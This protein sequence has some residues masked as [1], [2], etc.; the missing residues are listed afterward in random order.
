MRRTQTWLP[1]VLVVLAGCTPQPRP[2]A[3]PANRAPPPPSLDEA[4]A[5]ERGAGVPRDYARAAEI[6]AL[7]CD[8]G[9]GSIEACNDL[10]DAILD[11]RGAT[12]DLPRVLRLQQALCARG[13]PLACVAEAYLEAARP[14]GS[15]AAPPG[16]AGALDH[17]MQQLATACEHGDGRACEATAMGGDGDTAEWDRRRKYSVACLAGLMDACGRV[18]IDLEL[19]GEP[20][21]DATVAC[22]QRTVAEWRSHDYDHDLAADAQKLYDECRAGNAQACQHIPSQRIPMAT[23]CAAHD[24]GACAQLGCV[25]D[26]A[27]R[28]IA[29]AHGADQPNC[30]VAGKQ[31]YL[32][33]RRHPGQARFPPLVTDGQRPIG[34]RATPPWEAVRFQ[35]HGGRDAAD[36]PRFDVYDLDD[37]A[38]VELSVCMY[39]YDQAGHQLASFAARPKID[40]APNAMVPLALP[41]AGEPQL[42]AGTADVVIDYDHVRFAGGTTADDP[43]RCPAQRPGAR[44]G[45]YTHW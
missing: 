41:A 10:I 14:P 3:L 1:A 45:A 13:E 36:W 38:V 15:G 27:A 26:D 24:Y 19:C 12:A 22:E 35:H 29:L 33:W 4:R 9:H 11:A 28:Q 39:A 7:L 32:E 20:E 5:A 23:L 31:A 25:G 43:A 6:Y 42:P 30:Y 37:H 44:P 2:D 8:R 34:A 21:V 18:A 17:A 16:D 40:V